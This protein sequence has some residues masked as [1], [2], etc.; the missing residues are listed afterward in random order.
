MLG[1]LLRCL[2]AHI[3]SLDI[4]FADMRL[5]LL[6]KEWVLLKEFE[7]YDNT[8]AD[9]LNL[10]R[11][12]KMDIDQKIKECQEKLNAKKIEIEQIIA[13]EKGNQEE[14]NR[15]L[16][17][18]NKYEDLLTKI[19]KKKIKRSKVGCSLSMGEIIRI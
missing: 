16:G 8:L 2:N 1:C 10:K 7:K 4:T 11:T 14:F 9:K 18:N 3:Y 13:R 6:Y 17:E 15:A 5:L 12:E 19:F